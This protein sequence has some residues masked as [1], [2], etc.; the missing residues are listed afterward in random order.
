MYQLLNHVQLCATPWTV[1]HQASLPMGFPR[2]E[3]CRRLPFPTAD[4]PDAGIKSSSLA[5]PVLAGGFFTTSATWEVEA[6]MATHS[7]IPAWRIP[8]TEEPGRLQAMGS[9]RVEHDCSDLAHRVNYP[10]PGFRLPPSRAP[11]CWGD[12]AAAEGKALKHLAVNCD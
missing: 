7:S 9:H 5:S 12:K 10:F 1:A 11:R 2:Q 8:W 4:L 3:Y 6:G